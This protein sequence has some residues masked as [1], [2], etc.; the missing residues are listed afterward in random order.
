MKNSKQIKTTKSTNVFQVLISKEFG[1]VKVVSNLKGDGYVQLSDLC[2][3]LNIT[4]KEA[5]N[6]L[7][8]EYLSTITVECG[9]G[10]QQPMLFVNERA[11]YM[12]Y[13][14]SYEASNLRFQEWLDG[15]FWND[16]RK[17]RLDSNNG[18]KRV[19][20]EEEAEL[21]MLRSII[22]AHNVQVSGRFKTGKRIPELTMAH[23]MGWW[24]N[25]NDKSDFLLQFDCKSDFFIY[26]NVRMNVYLSKSKEEG[27]EGCNMIIR[28]LD[29]DDDNYEFY[30]EDTAIPDFIVT[31]N[32]ILEYIFDDLFHDVDILDSENVD[33]VA[34]MSGTMSFKRS[35]RIPKE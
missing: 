7:P 31:D 21:H 14:L 24:Y 26:Q 12:L 27:L 33:L 10:M 15:E 23:L 2:R 20:W 3:V 25:P 18:S 32:E 1:E 11:T 16:L 34:I 35:R 22:T 29:L 17:Q 28:F 6:L 4:V 8:K 30:F 13:M 5:I 9:K 19:D